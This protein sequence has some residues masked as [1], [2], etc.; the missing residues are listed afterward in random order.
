MK[1][2]FIAGLL[3]FTALVLLRST[4]DQS[5]GVYNIR[6]YVM[7]TDLEV[8]VLQQ[9]EGLSIESQ[10]KQHLRVVHVVGELRWRREVTE[11]HPL[12]GA[13]EDHR[14]IDVGPPRFGIF[15]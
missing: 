9:F 1:G 12:F 4:Q 13:V 8:N 2:G 10:V 6:Y 5:K 7:T 3:C 15:L 14:E 11:R